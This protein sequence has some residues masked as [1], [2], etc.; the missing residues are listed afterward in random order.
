MI[1]KR[2]TE[3]QVIRLP[4]IPENILNNCDLTENVELYNIVKELVNKND[5][6]IKSLSTFIYNKVLR[7]ITYLLF[8]IK[9]YT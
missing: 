8:L 3:S 4:Q 7:K 1:S 6:N 2:G 5:N 9:L